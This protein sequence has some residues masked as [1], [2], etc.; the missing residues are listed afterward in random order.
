MRKGFR[1]LLIFGLPLVAALSLWA[2]EVHGQGAQST[3]A[4][5]PAN[6]QWECK[7]FNFIIQTERIGNTTKDLEAFLQ[8]A[9]QVHFVSSGLPGNGSPYEGHY[10]VIACRQP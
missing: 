5:P 4:N 3:T 2:W 1:F 9:R 8:T 7:R 6:S 10:D